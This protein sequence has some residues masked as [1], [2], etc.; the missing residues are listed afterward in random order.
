MSEGEKRDSEGEGRKKA[1]RVKGEGRKAE[2]EGWREER[3]DL[4]GKDREK[5]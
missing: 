5:T 3:E 2:G 1:L 4:L